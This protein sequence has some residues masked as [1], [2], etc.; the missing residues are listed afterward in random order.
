MLVDQML[1]PVNSVKK[2]GETLTSVQTF[3][4]QSEGS[5]HEYESVNY[6]GRI[7]KFIVYL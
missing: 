5:G 7:K 4:E 1:L 2:A 6:F 3:L